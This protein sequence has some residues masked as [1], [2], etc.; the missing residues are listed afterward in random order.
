MA[1]IPNSPAPTS[2]VQGQNPVSAPGFSPINQQDLKDPGLTK[3]NYLLQF[4][5]GK[6]TALFG[7]GSVSL[8]SSPTFAR[9]FS[10]QQ[11]VANGPTAPNEFITF[12]FLNSRLTQSLGNATS[13]VAAPTTATTAYQS[14]KINNTHLP[15]RNILHIETGPNV[16][17]AASDVDAGATKLSFTAAT[18]ATAQ[19]NPPISA[20]MIQMQSRIMALESEVE[21]L[22][23]K[24]WWK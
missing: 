19:A 12:A 7:Q 6:L 9:A 16:N 15:P 22:K 20:D 3:L 23:S 8:F 5:Y 11:T 13:S 10:S 24:K 4:L 21:R 17:I 2:L 1:T 14:I 18:A